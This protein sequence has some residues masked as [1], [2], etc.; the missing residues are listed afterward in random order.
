M[1][2]YAGIIILLDRRDFAKIYCQNIKTRVQT[3]PELNCLPSC[4][5]IFK[6]YTMRTPQPQKPRL[7][8]QVREALRYYKVEA[9]RGQRSAVTWEWYNMKDFKDLTVLLKGMNL[10][11]KERRCII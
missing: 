5:V 4:T 9:V 6:V 11:T 1:T 2:E 7:L 3:M 10:W 8:D